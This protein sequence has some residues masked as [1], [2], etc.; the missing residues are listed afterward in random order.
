[1]SGDLHTR[2]WYH[3]FCFNALSAEQQDFLVTRGYLPITYRPEGECPNGASVE[4]TTIWDRFPGPR[5]YCVTCAV[6]YL[7]MLNN[8]TP[9]VRAP[10][11]WDSCTCERRVIGGGAGW[12]DHATDCA[13]RI[14]NEGVTDG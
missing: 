14:E 9:M 2:G 7:S 8:T 1:M 11:P 5:F 10:M 12:Y 13:Y 4:V 6:S 3:M